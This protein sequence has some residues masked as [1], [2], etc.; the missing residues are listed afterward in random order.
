MCGCARRVEV[1]WSRLHTC[2]CHSTSHR[3]PPEMQHLP[4]AMLRKAF[5]SQIQQFRVR[6]LQG[7]GRN[8][9]NLPQPILA[10][11]NGS[12]GAPSSGWDAFDDDLEEDLSFMATFE[13]STRME[14]DT[15]PVSPPATNASGPLASPSHALLHGARAAAAAPLTTLLRRPSAVGPEAR[16]PPPPVQLFSDVDPLIEVR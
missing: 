10:S 7:R 2:V 13:R 12:S 3:Q 9:I 11:S 14:S 8:S 4:H 6:R 16:K 15:V 1:R 5:P